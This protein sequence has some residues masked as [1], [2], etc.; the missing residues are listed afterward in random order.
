MLAYQY[1]RDMESRVL[2]LPKEK[3]KVS[4]QTWKA[5]LIILWHL[6]SHANTLV[7]TLISYFGTFMFLGFA[8]TLVV[9][10]TSL[11][12]QSTWKSRE[13]QNLNGRVSSIL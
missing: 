7:K 4:H 9:K 13:G 8:K 12:I 10:L 11:R 2:D 6:C 1:C 3:K 5:R